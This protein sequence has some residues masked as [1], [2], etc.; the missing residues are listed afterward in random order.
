MDKVCDTLFI[1]EN[2]GSV[3]GYVGKCS[4]YLQY[5][6]EIQ[7]EEKNNEKAL[8]KTES[9]KTNASPENARKKRTYK[10]QKEFEEI[11]KRIEEAENR[12]KILETEMAS[13]DYE[14]VK[15]AG[16]EYSALEKQ[17]KTD[18]ARWE[19]LAELEAN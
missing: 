11:E 8:A 18:Y 12:M 15:A 2:D 6:N 4:E 10:E 5:K 16:D 9:V 7:A 14:K 17:L 1:L 13:E 19:E 3:S